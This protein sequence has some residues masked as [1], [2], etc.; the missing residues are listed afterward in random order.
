MQFS[1]NNSYR[2]YFRSR[3]GV[4]DIIEN[5]DFYEFGHGV[6]AYTGTYLEVNRIEVMG[7]RALRVKK[8]YK[9]T[10]AFLRVIGRYATKNVVKLD[11]KEALKFMQGEKVEGVC[12]ATRGYVVVK[13]DDD[14]LGCGLCAGSLISQIP[15]KYRVEKT[16]L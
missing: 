12:G 10:T 9:P 4:G 14:V 5:Y 7:I 16:W 13:R 3:F 1:R 8:V 11:E 6:W 15:R 2:D